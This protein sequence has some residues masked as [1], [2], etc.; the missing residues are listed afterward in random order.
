MLTDEQARECEGIILTMQFIQNSMDQQLHHPE[1]PEWLQ[2]MI[3]KQYKRLEDELQLFDLERQEFKDKNEFPRLWR[4]MQADRT[5]KSLSDTQLKRMRLEK[6]L[7]YYTRNGEWISKQIENLKKSIS[8]LQT[9]TL[10]N[11]EKRRDIEEELLAM[12]DAEI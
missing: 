6:D 1:W 4:W 3:K 2:L 8:N 12:Q 9:Y 7:S 10:K 11:E 5:K